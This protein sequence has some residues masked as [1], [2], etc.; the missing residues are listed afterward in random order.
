MIN[1]TI[2]FFLTIALFLTSCGQNRQVGSSKKPEA[3]Q[4][5]IPDSGRETS[6]TNETSLTL[7]SSEEESTLIP[8][9]PIEAKWN[10]VKLIDVNLDG[11]TNEEQIIILEPKEGDDKILEIWISDYSTSSNSHI[12]AWKDKLSVKTSEKL[13]ITVNESTNQGQFEIYIIGFDSRDY[14]TIDVFYPLS[15]QTPKYKN[16]FSQSVKGT[17]ELY[18]PQTAGSS[19]SDDYGTRVRI[20]PQI[21]ITEADETASNSLDSIVTTWELSYSPLRYKV[22]STR[23]IRPQKE[24]EEMLLGLMS[25]TTDDFENLL[26]DY[27]Y[28]EESNNGAIYMLNIDNKNESVDLLT[29]T[30][31][32]H[33]NWDTSYKYSYA[34]RLNIY[35]TSEYIDSVKEKLTID[36]INTDT[37]K[38]SLFD[39]GSPNQNLSWSGT[40]K[41]MTEG[42]KLSLIKEYVRTINSDTFELKGKYK[43]TNGEELFF[44]NNTFTLS[45]EG[46]SKLETGYFTLFILNKTQLMELVFY[47]NRGIITKREQYLFSYNVEDNKEHRIRS[48]LIS[49]GQTTAHGFTPSDER[50]KRFE[51]IELLS[52]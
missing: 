11:D 42:M 48:F 26:S 43:S 41:R 7:N 40:Y 5:I 35:A 21:I 32:E 14:H 49:S 19:L 15:D 39:N 20:S 3:G 45:R 10:I 51:Q 12:L 22:I 17:I 31:F 2:I 6:K 23:K 33:F 46:S 13:I 8:Y 36:V 25:G 47:D 29:L 44:D 16:I 30:N 27:W 4:T 50:E 37:V 52:N 28:K 34:P 38:L 18:Y 24:Q 1:R 9:I